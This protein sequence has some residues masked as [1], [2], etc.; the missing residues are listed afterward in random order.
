MSTCCRVSPQYLMVEFH[1]TLTAF[2]ILNS[3]LESKNVMC[4]AKNIWVVVWCCFLFENA[5]ELWLD[6]SGLIQHA[7]Q[8]RDI[9]TLNG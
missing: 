3:T 9:N 4:V 8:A 7:D 6:A 2:R 5:L 1:I